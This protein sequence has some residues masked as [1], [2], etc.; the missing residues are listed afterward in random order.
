[1]VSNTTSTC[2]AVY[3]DQD[4]SGVGVTL[5]YVWTN[6]RSVFRYTFSRV[7]CFS[8]TLS[9]TGIGLR[10]LSFKLASTIS[11]SISSTSDMVFLDY[12]INTLLPSWFTKL[13]SRM[14][15]SSTYFG[16]IHWTKPKL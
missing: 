7:N 1:M 15:H 5:H 6:D 11:S 4:V 10:R 12:S 14:P 13:C 9:A 2:L 8:S 3:G 16:D